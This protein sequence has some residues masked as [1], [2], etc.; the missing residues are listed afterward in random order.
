MPH[1]SYSRH[2]SGDSQKF[3]LS[4]PRAETGERESSS[5]RNLSTDSQQT[6][7]TSPLLLSMN[8]MPQVSAQHKNQPGGFLLDSSEVW[9][10]YKGVAIRGWR[11]IFSMAGLPPQ[12]FFPSLH[13]AHISTFERALDH[14]IA[15]WYSINQPHTLVS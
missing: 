6:P 1:Y 15:P 11:V 5:S 2:P 9:V 4:P 3:P 13:N 12:A 10:C 8:A 14:C 7:P